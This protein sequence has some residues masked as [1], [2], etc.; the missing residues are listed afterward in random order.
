[1]VDATVIANDWSDFIDGDIIAPINTDENGVSYSS[2]NVR[3][4]TYDNGEK[5]DENC[6]NWIT[7]VFDY[8]T[9]QYR[10]FGGYAHYYTYGWSYSF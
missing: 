3:T 9:D 7:D 4:A 8:D 10:S 1:M 5:T 2:W 6:L